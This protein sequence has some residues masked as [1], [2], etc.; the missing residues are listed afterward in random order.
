[1]HRIR[2]AISLSLLV[3]AIKL[4]PSWDGEIV[5]E[6]SPECNCIDG[7]TKRAGVYGWDAEQRRYRCIPDT[8]HVITE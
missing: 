3:V 8:C 5:I 2:I 1:M 4:G 6:G 7:F